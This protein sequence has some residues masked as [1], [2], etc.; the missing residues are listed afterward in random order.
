MQ[1]VQQC[2]RDGRALNELDLLFE[3]FFRIRVET[4][5]ESARNLLR[6]SLR[7]G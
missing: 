7:T 3:D 2:P 6:P 5:D 1:R 4:Y